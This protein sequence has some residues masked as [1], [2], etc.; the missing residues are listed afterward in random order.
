MSSRP[1]APRGSP[2]RLAVHWLTVPGVRKVASAAKPAPGW[3]PQTLQV[4]PGRRAGRGRCAARAAGRGSV[5][6]RDGVGVRPRAGRRSVQREEPCRGPK[7]R[8]EAAGSG[9]HSAAPD[10]LVWSWTASWGESRGER[11]PPPPPRDPVNRRDL[12]R[13]GRARLGRPSAAGGDARGFGSGPLRPLSVSGRPGRGGDPRTPSGRLAARPQRCGVAWGLPDAQVRRA[14]RDQ[15]QRGRRPL[16]GALGG[17]GPL[18][19]ANERAG[20]PGRPRPPGP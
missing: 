5:P 11:R 14:G 12:P 18:L 4:P 16:S 8:Q 13:A 1:C 19:P 7:G 15:T 9:A 10:L 20:S 17:P 2:R 3:T 6:G